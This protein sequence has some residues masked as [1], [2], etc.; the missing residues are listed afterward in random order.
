MRTLSLLVA[1]LL[2]AA[3]PP[4]VSAQTNYTKVETGPSH[5]LGIS[6]ANGAS[7]TTRQPGN[8]AVLLY[9]SLDEQGDAP[10]DLVLGWWR[11]DEHDPDG[12]FTTE[13]QPCGEQSSGNGYVAVGGVRGSLGYGGATFPPPYFEMNTQEGFPIFY[14]A[15]GIRA[16]LNSAG[17]RVKGIRLFGSAVNQD[18]AGGVQREPAFKRDFERPNCNTWKLARRCPE[19]EVIVGLDIHHTGDNITGFAPK[20]AEVTATLTRVTER[21]GG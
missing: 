5:T 13:F 16:C 1:A 14:A 18:G 12:F 21:R 8:D 10:C 11:H 19:G 6:G 20:C 4:V 2:L 3:A 17:T 15:H 7:I 9:L